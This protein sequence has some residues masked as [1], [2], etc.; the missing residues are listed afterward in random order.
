M[1]TMDN[2]TLPAH[3]DSLEPI[4][5]YVMQAAKE[6]GLDKKKTYKLRLA[7][8]EI[9][10]NVI[11]YGYGRSGMTGNINL[12][13]AIDNQSLTLILEDT[14]PEFDPTKR[15][16]QRDLDAPLEERPIGGLGIY[17]AVEGVDRFEYQRVGDRNRN[18]FIVNL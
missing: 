11:N 2:L 4:A 5:H 18:I 13:V 17:L 16:L 6:A 9:A 12:N 3:L 14:S 7:V 8:D 1:Q 15:E 10:T